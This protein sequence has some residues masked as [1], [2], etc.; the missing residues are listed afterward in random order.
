MNFCF[1]CS[2]GC[3]KEFPESQDARKERELA[4]DSAVAELST[5][6]QQQQPPQQQ[7]QTPVR[8]NFFVSESGAAGEQRLLEREEPD[9]EHRRTSSGASVGQVDLSHLQK[10]QHQPEHDGIASLASPVDA[11]GGDYI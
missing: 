7:A 9:Q 10:P 5:A 6:Q 3:S 4:T 11:S 8:D 1:C 2:F